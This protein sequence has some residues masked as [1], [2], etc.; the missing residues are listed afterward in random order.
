MAYAHFEELEEVVVSTEIATR[1]DDLAAFILGSIVQTHRHNYRQQRQ[2]TG[3]SEEGEGDEEMTPLS[4]AETEELSPLEVGTQA[5]EVVEKTLAILQRQ[6]KALSSGGAHLSTPEI[7]KR[8]GS[9]RS[10]DGSG[11]GGGGRQNTLQMV[12]RK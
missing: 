4:P 5:V 3:G 9:L 12:T 11:G 1:P 2:V 6:V 7:M 8:Y 10:R